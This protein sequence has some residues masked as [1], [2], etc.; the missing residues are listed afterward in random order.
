MKTK[1][2]V[3]TTTGEDT[4]ISIAKILFV[5]YLFTGFIPLFGAM[6]Y[7]A[8][9]WLYVSIL[10]IVSL[11]FIV[12]N[13]TFFSAFSFG[14]K[15][16]IFLLLFLSFI[17]IGFLS[18][19]KAVN[20]SESLVHLSRLISVFVTLY[21]LLIFF[22]KDPISFFH[23]ICKSA[24]L[25]VAYFSLK[26]IVYFIGN[27]YSPRTHEFLKL[28]PHNYANTNIYAAYLVVQF[29]FFVYGFIFFKKFWKYAAG[30][31][32][33]M[34]T[35]ALFFAAAR[36]ALL[37]LIIIFIITIGYLLV[38]IIKDKL[39]LK[40][41]VFFLVLTPILSIFLVL[42]V[43]KLDRNSMNSI[44]ELMVSQSADFYK[45]KE[46][47]R[48]NSVAIDT[49]LPK[50]LKIVVANDFGS[51]RFSIWNLAFSKFKEN[52]L[53][54][55]GYGNFK[56]T[57][58]KEHYLK[59]A[60]RQGIYANPRRVHNDFLEKLAETG[61]V[62]FIGYVSLFIFPF[63]ILLKIFRKE[64]DIKKQYILITILAS[65]IA[66]TLDALLNFPLERPP[67]QLYFILVVVLIMSLAQK[68]SVSKE[69]TY[70]KHKYL[71]LGILFL[72][73]FASIA[74]NYVVFKSYKLQRT[75]RD[76]I[77][78][79]RLFTDE[80]MQNSYQSIK[81]QW[82]NYPELSYVGTVNKVY[83]ANYAIKA[84]KYEEA[85][86]ILNSSQKQNEDAFLVKV[87]KAEIYLNVYDKTDSAKYYSKAVF[88]D[89]PGFKTNYIL[90]KNIYR[91][92]KDSVNLFRIMNRYSKINPADVDEWKVK[93]N[94]VYDYT[95]DSKLM[96]KVLDTGLAYNRSSNILLEAK[97]EVLNKLK[98]KS[99][100]SNEEVKA[101]HQI[102]FNFF[103]QQKYE[104]ARAV[105]QEILKTNPKDYLSIQNIGIIDL[106][107]KD[108]E[109]A[110]RNLTIVIRANAFSDGKA[111]YSRGYCYE[112]LGKIDKA[113]A[114]Y[115]ISRNKK[116]P[117]AMSLPETK[118]K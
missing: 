94:M 20:V 107:K 16:K 62:G 57:G 69:T 9:E 37:S 111:E 60:H 109:K 110:I 95:K 21:C 70:V 1:K 105:F 98:F 12:K 87:F 44:N 59:Y 75:M 103:K 100:L 43:N 115:I 56:A 32:V 38:A 118:Y 3:N 53:L 64:K 11:I 5:L 112:Q 50:D 42:N 26:A 35:L 106:V 14:K 66:Y 65:A 24:I 2:A 63:I 78:G 80:K 17:A 108:Y 58:K 72:F 104:D 96:M 71:I 99:Y 10:N 117:Q 83:L 7:D 49:L 88:D 68:D 6:D 77:Q 90:L 84:K 91:K 4:N 29:P 81:K 74:S 82:T 92:E 39:P 40:R 22:R 76:D 8:P 55:I 48:R 52:P 41:E 45:G 23:L 102:A 79:K 86:E 61:V 15:S 30:V 67:I 46:A 31:V 27:Y 33:L 89:Y 36:T 101:K 93:A 28:F 34:A 18:I 97:K 47:A 114:D 73:S 51:G 25:I 19:I 85:L 54:G 13:S 116:Y 113:K